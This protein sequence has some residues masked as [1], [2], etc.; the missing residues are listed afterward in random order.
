MIPYHLKGQYILHDKGELVIEEVIGV[1]KSKYG[2]YIIKT[3]STEV[4]IDEDLLIRTGRNI[5][6]L[7]R[8]G[9]IAIINGEIYENR[10]EIV[11][12]LTKGHSLQA[13]SAQG[14]L[15][16][17]IEGDIIHLYDEIVYY[18]DKLKVGTISKVV[19]SHIRVGKVIKDAKEVYKIHTIDES[20]SDEWQDVCIIEDPW[21]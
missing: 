9:D 8:D 16:R 5:K 14:A 4:D 18:D 17:D 20:I 6:D 3:P 21:K 13:I 11:K 19:G 15:P 2:G 1:F 10:E 12:C 7:I